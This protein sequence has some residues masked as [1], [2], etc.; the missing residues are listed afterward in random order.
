MIPSHY[1]KQYLRCGFIK[2]ENLA[3]LLRSWEV[4][5][6]NNQVRILSFSYKTCGGICVSGKGFPPSTTV[7]IIPQLLRAFLCEE[8]RTKPENLQN[9]AL[10]KYKSIGY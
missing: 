6:R 1:P 9:H 3:L 2:T 10:L 7:A 5:V 8:R 4:C